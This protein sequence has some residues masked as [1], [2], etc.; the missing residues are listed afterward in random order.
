MAIVFGACHRALR[1]H[2]QQK[3]NQGHYAG[4]GETETLLHGESFQRQNANARKYKPYIAVRARIACG[5]R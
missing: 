3:Q 4:R 1:D 5:E 2:C